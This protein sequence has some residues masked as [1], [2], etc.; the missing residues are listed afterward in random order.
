[1]PGANAAIIRAFMRLAG[2]DAELIARGMASNDVAA[3][4]FVHALLQVGRRWE[5]QISELDAAWCYELTLSVAGR[6]LGF[7]LT[8]GGM[9]RDRLPTDQIG[10][11]LAD[12]VLA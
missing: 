3:A 11:Y 12:T 8:M 5:M 1:M 6:Q 4:T 7:G 10:S 2:G 9:P